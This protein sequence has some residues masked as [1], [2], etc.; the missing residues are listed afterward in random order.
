MKVAASFPDKVA[1]CP[2]RTWAILTKYDNNRDFVA[3][4]EE[5]KISI[6]QYQRAD[7]Y[8]FDL[9]DR[10]MEDKILI[11]RVQSI[12]ADPLGHVT[13]PVADAIPVSVKTLIEQRQKMKKQMNLI[14]QVVDKM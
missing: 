12:L 11:S 3:W 10:F 9:L 6:P 5:N 8:T 13:S 4:A 14:V 7:A 1:A 2:Q